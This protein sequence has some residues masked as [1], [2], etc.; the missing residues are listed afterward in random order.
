VAYVHLGVLPRNEE[1][2]VA[3]FAEFC[4]GV[5]GAE[6]SAVSGVFGS[7]LVMSTRALS[8][9]A[10]LGVRLREMFC[11]YGSAG[12]HPIMA[13]AV[14]RLASWRA[15]HPFETDAELAARLGA[16]LR[17]ALGTR[18]ERER[19]T[20]KGMRGRQAADRGDRRR[21]LEPKAGGCDELEPPLA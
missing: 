16:Q 12:G 19:S 17:E 20:T 6:I 3:Q 10:Q 1:H 7:K 8:P 9:E 13:K 11:H 2:V 5:A 4:L 21:H 15:D 14:L 18:P